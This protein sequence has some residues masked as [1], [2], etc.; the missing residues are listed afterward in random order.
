MA[1]NLAERL[2]PP[3][4]WMDPSLPPRWMLPTMYDL[5]SEEP[6][7]PGMPDEFHTRQPPLL[8]ETFRP[9]GLVSE[10]IFTAIDL[11]LY[12]DPHHPKWY[13]RP[14]WFVVL[15]PP[16]FREYEKEMRMSYVVWQEEAAPTLVLEMLSPG[17]EDEDLSWR[18]SDNLENRPP[19]KWEVYERLLQVP[20]YVVY[21]HRTKELFVFRWMT[22]GYRSVAVK[23]GR[24]WLR[25]IGLGIG[26]WKGKYKRWSGVW[27]RWFDRQNR[28]IP[29]AEELEREQQQQTERERQRA[30]QERQRAEQER[31]RAEQERQRAEQERQRAEQALQQADQ[32]RERAD[33][34]AQRLRALGFDPNAPF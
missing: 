27:L 16:H 12:Y 7:E 10:R 29:N 30:E 21:N 26:L 11:N 9:P 33:R 17:T 18:L 8:E 3:P 6:G 23:D 24:C 32:E 34:L 22:D 25:E 31:Q 19:S 1:T 28:W 13:K 14:D 5:P 2:P 20:L 4:P 15:N